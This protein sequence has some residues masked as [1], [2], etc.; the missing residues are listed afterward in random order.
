MRTCGRCQELH[1][2]AQTTCGCGSS[3]VLTR[4]QVADSDRRR[5]ELHATLAAARARR[6]ARTVGAR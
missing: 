5:A 3:L 1:D 6:I 4:R 2:D